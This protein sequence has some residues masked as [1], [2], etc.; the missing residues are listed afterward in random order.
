MNKKTMF[1]LSMNYLCRINKDYP[2][3]VVVA[4]N[5]WF[6]CYDL[7]GLID[8]AVAVQFVDVLPRRNKYRN[9]YYLLWPFTSSW[10]MYYDMDRS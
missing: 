5:K 8:Y 9:R 10:F 4:S 7:T 3:L 6:P 1:E 2:L